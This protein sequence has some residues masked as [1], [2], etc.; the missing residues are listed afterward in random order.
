ME[1]NARTSQLPT[2]GVA[3][4]ASRVSRALRLDRGVF[5]EVEED[6]GALPEAVV[7]VILAGLSRG[8]GVVPSEG[9]ISLVANPIAALLLWSV[10]GLIIW[11]V[12]VGRFEYTSNYRELLR[13]T[14]YAASPLLFLATC[15]LVPGPPAL[16]INVLAHAWAALALVVAV[17]E[18][19][20]I[21][22][23]RAV[24]VCLIALAVGLGLIVLGGILFAGTELAA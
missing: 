7:V 11:A 6:A 9:W 2:G 13:T 23:T 19:L 18:A 14:A 1:G 22:T 3:R 17:R 8:A 10:A 20:D 15:A 5:E 24:W 4:I 12:G 16:A 21:A